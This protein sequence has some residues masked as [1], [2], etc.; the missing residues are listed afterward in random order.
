[1]GRSEV[2][3]R[4]GRCDLLSIEP[5]LYLRG[6]L[7]FMQMVE[8]EDCMAGQNIRNQRPLAGAEDAELVPANAAVAE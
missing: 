7:K 1:M 6:D 5:S 3:Y 2:S 8:A 4:L